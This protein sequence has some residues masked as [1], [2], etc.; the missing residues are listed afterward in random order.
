VVQGPFPAFGGGNDGGDSTFLGF[1]Y[2]T[3][4]DPSNVKTLMQANGQTISV[5]ANEA[6]Y[7]LLSN[8]YGGEGLSN[9]QLPD[10]PDLP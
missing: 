7:A 2:Q 6:L 1:I 3:A 8:T 4:F 5:S 9:Y 10:M